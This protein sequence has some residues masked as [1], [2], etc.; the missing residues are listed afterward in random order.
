MWPPGRSPAGCRTHRQQAITALLSNHGVV[1][2]SPR[3]ASGRSPGVQWFLFI[4]R[5]SSR[6]PHWTA[7][8][9]HPAPEREGTGT[10]G[11][12]DTLWIQDRAMAP[13][14]R[15]HGGCGTLAVGLGPCRSSRGCDN[16]TPDWEAGQQ[17]GISVS[18][19]CRPERKGLFQAPPQ[20]CMWPSLSPHMVFPLRPC[21]CP[22]FLFIYLFIETHHI[23]WGPTLTASF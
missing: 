11:R 19:A 21:L 4:V 16:H 10:G 15:A 1:T 23:G 18:P 22:N 3:C 8:S 20:A 7:R 6:T 12:G 5:L 17:E 14:W 13:P 9:H 2:Q